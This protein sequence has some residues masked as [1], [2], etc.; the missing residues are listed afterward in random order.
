VGLNLANL[1]DKEYY[2]FSEIADRWN[3][4]VNL[5]QQLIYQEKLRPA[6]A[7]RELPI[8]GLIV[9]IDKL[10]ESSPLR[11][12]IGTTFE[13]W[14]EDFSDQEVNTMDIAIEG[15]EKGLSQENVLNKQLILTNDDLRKYRYLYYSL[16]HFVS[17]KT[18][19]GDDVFCLGKIQRD[20][21]TGVFSNLRI[22]R[23]GRKFFK[24]ITKMERDRFEEEFNITKDTVDVEKEV[25]V[26]TENKHIELI[27][28]FADVLLE[29]GLSE[30]PYS[31]AAKIERVLST[32]GK[33]LPCTIETLGNYLKKPLS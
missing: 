21:E 5:I 16:Q 24:Y 9:D 28:L 11:S 18:F 13:I 33:N 22:S 14:I 4:D 8:V 2:S 31:D 27:Q 25:S 23:L 30:K 15:A 26:K 1:P 17:Y 12:F 7:L 29:N 6:C 3:C 19:E 20:V 10:E 32:K